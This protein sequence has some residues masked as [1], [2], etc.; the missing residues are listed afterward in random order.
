VRTFDTIEELRAAH[1]RVREGP[2]RLDAGRESY[3]QR[4]LPRPVFLQR[5]E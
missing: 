1:V 3:K 2:A 5:D 4:A